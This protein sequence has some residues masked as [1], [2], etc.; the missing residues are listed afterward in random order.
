MRM[1]NGAR[2]AAIIAVLGALLGLVFAT[3]STTDYAAHLDR[4]LHE[5]HCSVIPGAPPKE[6]AE[7]CRA[8]LYSPYAAI[9]KDQVWGG[10]PISLFAQGA[11]AFFAGFGLYLAVAGSRASK[12]AAW[13]FAAAGVTPAFVSIAML[14]IS[15][16][17]LNT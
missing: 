17:Q 2:I 10:L 6:E 12:A 13:F 16:T 8:A 9:L 15:L 4:Q 1:G 5:L 14:V 11:F 3:Y 7:G